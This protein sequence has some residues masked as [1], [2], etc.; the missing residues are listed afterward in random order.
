MPVA[1]R[2]FP[3]EDYERRLAI[4]R[5]EAQ[6]T[7]K[8]AVGVAAVLHALS[9]AF[10]CAG[11]WAGRDAFA[12]FA[13]AL[14]CVSVVAAAVAGVLALRRWSLLSAWWLAFGL[15]PWGVIASELS[16][17]ILAMFLFGL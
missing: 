14:W 9:I 12:W 7:V 15:L 13:I 10:L 16:L 3:A 8:F 5:S 2:S 11:V 17:P 1:A 4:Q 6:E